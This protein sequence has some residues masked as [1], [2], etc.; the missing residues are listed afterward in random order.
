MNYPQTHRELLLL[1]AGLPV[2]RRLGAASVHTV[3]RVVVCRERE[4]EEREDRSHIHSPELLNRAVK[5]ETI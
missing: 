3:V 4:E 2:D 5:A 1:P